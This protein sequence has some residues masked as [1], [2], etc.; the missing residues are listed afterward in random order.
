VADRIY[1]EK[2]KPRLAGLFFG[3]RGHAS[4]QHNGSVKNLRAAR[5]ALIGLW[6]GALGSSATA[7]DPPLVAS[8]WPDT[9]SSRLEALALLQTLNADLLSQD[10]A[11]LTLERWC[12]VHKLAPAPHI[13]AVLVPGMPKAASAEQRTALHVAATETV[14]Y[15]HVQLVCGS[16]VLSEADNWYVP[17]RLT[18]QMNHLLETTDRPFG[19]IVRDLHFQRHTLSSRLLW[20]P[21]PP[22]WEMSP[23]HAQ[24]DSGTLPVPA[25]VLEHRA[26]LSL[27]DG[28]PFSEVV[29]TYTG[30]VLAFPAPRAPTHE[31]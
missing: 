2:L 16:L 24:Q 31:R 17:A 10:S 7:T 30:N 27:P 19:A 21:L 29:E 26:V 18:P 15:R 1:F 8:D 11:T 25:Q 4:P 5:C 28:T 6:L 23:G 3:S 9:F 22:A 12:A 14:R 13:V 20:M